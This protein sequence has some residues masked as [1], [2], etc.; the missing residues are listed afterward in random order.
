MLLV[1][2]LLIPFAFDRLMLSDTW[3]RAISLVASAWLSLWIRWALLCLTCLAAI[4]ALFI[5]RAYRNALWWT[6][7][8]VIGALSVWLIINDDSFT[9]GI[10]D[11]SDM[12]MALP[13]P[14]YWYATLTSVIAL[15]SLLMLALQLSTT[16]FAPN[17]PANIMFRWLQGWTV[18]LFTHWRMLAQ[19]CSLCLHGSR[20]ADNDVI[21]VRNDMLRKIGIAMLISL[22]ILCLLIPLLMQAD[23]IF[24]YVV[25]HAFN[26]LDFTALLWHTMAVLIPFPFLASLLVSVDTRNEE[27]K[28]TALRNAEKHGLFDPAITA[29]VLMIVLALYAVFCVVQFTFLFAG[30]GLPAGYTYAEYARQ[31]FFQLLLVTAL[32]LAGFGLVLTFTS[33]TRL[34]TMLQVGLVLATGVMLASSAMRLWLYIDAYGLTWLRWL[35]LTFI[36]LLAVVLALALARLFVARL[37]L[38]GITFV[39]ILLWWLALGLSN[40]N[41][42]VNTWNTYFGTVVS[43]L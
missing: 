30:A 37:P 8:A 40:P 43:D 2:A 27:P 35:S 12:F 31:G 33:R 22:P 39:L 1:A 41:W 13:S 4:I 23:E 7:A 24:S 34:V 21:A 15:P 19:T 3:P 26:H 17:Q 25:V 20:D 14:N 42:V 11:H 9:Y 32:N 29:T 18:S 16:N 10:P 5:R 6:S 38:I 36:V 28:L